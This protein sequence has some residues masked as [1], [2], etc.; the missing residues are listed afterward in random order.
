MARA[1]WEENRTPQAAYVFLRAQ[2][3][4][5]EIHDRETA[6]H[7]GFYWLAVGWLVLSVIGGHVALVWLILQML[8]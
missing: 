1:D 8:R 7:I 3:E 4:C 5:D 6:Q 2:E